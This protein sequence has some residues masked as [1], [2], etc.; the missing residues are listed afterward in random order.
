MIKETT[1]LLTGEV[2]QEEVELEEAPI[3]VEGR[4][5]LPIRAVVEAF[6]AAVIWDNDTRTILIIAGVC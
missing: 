3:T 6:G 2:A 1:N 5:L 4:I